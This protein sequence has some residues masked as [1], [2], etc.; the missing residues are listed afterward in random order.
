MYNIL[1]NLSFPRKCH[2]SHRRKLQLVMLTGRKCVK[3]KQLK[4][5]NVFARRQKIH[6][7]SDKF[8]I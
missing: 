2:R 5:E 1:K 7:K 8:L 3:S 4:I 6:L